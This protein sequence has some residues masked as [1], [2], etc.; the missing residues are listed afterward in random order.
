MRGR[1][2]LP[3]IMVLS[4]GCGRNPAER[5]AGFRDELVYEQL[6]FSP[7]TATQVGYHQH[8][9]VNLDSILDNLSQAELDRQRQ[10]FRRFRER[11]NGA[12]KP[13]QLTAEDRADYD[14]IGDQISVQLL[15]LDEIQNWRHSPTVYVE[16]IGNA[17]FTPSILEIPR[18]LS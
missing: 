14:L 6:S 13:E 8:K 4:L 10:F 7:V 17:L 5:L 15:E 1:P 11:L 16:L 9:G 2:L 18:S 12:V 3:L